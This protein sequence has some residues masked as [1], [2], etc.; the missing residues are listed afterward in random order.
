MRMLDPFGGA[1][2]SFFGKLAM[3]SLASRSVISTRPSGSGIESSN[4]RDQLLSAIAAIPFLA[5]RAPRRQMRPPSE[6]MNPKAQSTITMLA[7]KTH[8]GE[9]GGGRT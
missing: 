9:V 7:I 3:Q 4:L 5:E 8:V 6:R 1:A 2:D